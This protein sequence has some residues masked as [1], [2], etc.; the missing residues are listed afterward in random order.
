MH[1]F[2]SIIRVNDIE[3][4][5]RIV[6]DNEYGNGTAIFTESLSNAQKYENE[7]NITQ[8]GINVPIPVSPPYFSWT[9]TKESY[10]GSHYIYGESALDFY[11]QKK[12]N[13]EKIYSKYEFKFKYAN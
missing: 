6:N 10:R 12:N 13:Y 9:S 3:Q 8:C 5:I 11:T 2:L 7:V 1:R 4:A